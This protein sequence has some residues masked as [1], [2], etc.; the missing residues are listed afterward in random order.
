M[1][2][3]NVKHTSEV[4][5]HTEKHLVP[6]TATLT[7]AYDNTT[8]NGIPMIAISPSQGK[9]L[10]LLTSMSGARN[11][12]ELGTLGGYSSIWFAQALKRN[13]GGKVTTIE[14]DPLHRDVSNA[15]LQYAGVSVPQEAEVLLGAGLDVLPLLEEEIEAGKR[16]R[17]DFVFVDADWENQWQYFDWG[18]KLC[19]G[20]GSVVYVDNVVRQLL[21]SG[22]VGPEKR[23]EGAVDLVEKVGG[24]GR[25]D[26]V[27]MQTVGAKDYDGFLMAVVK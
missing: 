22:V 6:P 4:E 18:V 27:V 7:H 8:A 23:E 9:F 25:V 5:A 12:L 1:S 20:R 3:E 24:D 15:N 2:V 16:A 21:E 17:F 14:V 19:K 11:V 26:A 10:S 13:G